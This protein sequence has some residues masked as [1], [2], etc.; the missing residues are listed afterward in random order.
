MLHQN[1]KSTPRSIIHCKMKCTK[2]EEY[3]LCNRIS[4][5]QRNLEIGFYYQLENTFITHNFS[6]SN[7]GI[8]FAFDL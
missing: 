5:N 4:E 6:I 1:T 3:G 2:A 8:V 7:I